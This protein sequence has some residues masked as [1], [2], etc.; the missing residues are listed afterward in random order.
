M[1][2]NYHTAIATG[3]AAN[4][5]VFNAPLAQLDAA[6]DTAIAAGVADLDDLVTEVE[7]A[8]DGYPT[9][10]DHLNAMELEGAGTSTGLPLTAGSGEALTGTLYMNP[11]SDD[12]AQLFRVPVTSETNGDVLFNLHRVAFSGIDDVVFNWGFNQSVGGGKVDA[13]LHSWYLQLE[14]DYSFGGKR[15]VEWHLNLDPVGG[16]SIFRPMQ[17]QYTTD[18]SEGLLYFRS[19]DFRVSNFDGTTVAFLASFPT[20]TSSDPTVQM[21]GYI[22]IV[23]RTA[24]PSMLIRNDDATFYQI[25]GTDVEQRAR[26]T[27]LMSA[28]GS[29]EYFSMSTTAGYNTSSRRLDVNSTATSQPTLQLTGPASH[30]GPLLSALNSAAAVQFQVGPA[31]QLRTNQAAENTATPSGATAYQLPIYNAAGTLLGY[32]PVYG[33]AWS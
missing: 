12:S 9:L 24:S 19:T 20:A 6:I 8:R 10:L 27:K 7:N 26:I 29:T 31:G 17:F 25:N 4:A 28:D 21:K 2:Q 16:A 22:D 23:P 32:I 18:G 14:F 5:S 33:S 1:T 3:A 30:T 13:G 15:W 11:G